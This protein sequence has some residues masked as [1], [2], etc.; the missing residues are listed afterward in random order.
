MNNKTCPNENCRNGY[1]VRGTKKAESIKR[2]QPGQVTMS[3]PAP[4]C[5]DSY[6]HL[7]A[8]TGS[9]KAAQGPKGA[10]KGPWGA[11]TH[12]AP[13]TPAPAPGSFSFLEMQT[14]VRQEML[15][16]LQEFKAAISPPVQTAAKE[17]AMMG[18]LLKELFSSPC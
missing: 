14:I 17:K 5:L 3:P 6:P 15:S 12:V 7:G 16:F 8:G 11:A 10:T 9:R 1:H 18:S 2:L 4:E 13:Q